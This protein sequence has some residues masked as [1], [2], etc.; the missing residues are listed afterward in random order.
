MDGGYSQKT[1]VKI[2]LLHIITLLLSPLLLFSQEVDIKRQVIGA[3]G[4]SMQ[5]GN[6]QISATIGETISGSSIGGQNIFTQGFQQGINNV[7]DSISYDYAVKEE[8]C[9]DT[10]DGEIILSNFEGCENG[11][12]TVQWKNGEVGPTLSNLSAGWYP[13]D[14]IACG[15]IST[16]SI[17]VG[18]IYESSCMMK[19]YS[20]FS[21]NGD[22][23]NDVWEID[24]I[25]AEPN[26]K[27]TVSIFNRWGNEVQDFVNYDNTSVVWN[28]KD[29]KGKEVTEGTYY[30]KV[31]INNENYSGYIELTR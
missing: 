19:F 29:K 18:R 27:N 13:F 6:L 5:N 22:G 10:D 16:D 28:G 17:Q 30:Y 12:Y 14:I 2:P 3:G 11:Q 15:I 1:K 25:N 7:V 31:K 8:T 21:P 23:I 24:N 4:S 26:A 20:A 9:P